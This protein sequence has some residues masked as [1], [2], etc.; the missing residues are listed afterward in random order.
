[1]RRV[2]HGHDDTTTE[3][4]SSDRGRLARPTL[5]GLVAAAVSIFLLAAASVLLLI[6]TVFFL[7]PISPDAD[8]V[9]LCLPGIGPLQQF[10]DGLQGE[11]EEVVY[12]HESVHADQCR[13]FGA[14]WYAL[15]TATPHGRLTLEAQAL[16]A[17]AAVLAR[18]GA[19]RERLLDR[20]VETLASGYFEDGVVPRMDISAAVDGACG[21]VPGD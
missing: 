10:R 7:V 5:S 9:T 15:R 16:C 17:E 21:G 4:M 1:M 20:T 2:P 14:A 19:S 8:G 11:R 6:P 18:R 13:M 3:A 12:I